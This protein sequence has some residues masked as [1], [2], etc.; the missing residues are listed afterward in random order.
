MCFAPQRHALFRHL[1]LNLQKWSEPLVFLTFWLR[2]VLRVTTAYTFSTSEP[3]KVVRTPGVFNILTSKCAW[4]HNGVHFFDIATSKS[5]P[6]MVCFVH[7]DLETCFA[8]QQRALFR[9]CNFQKWSDN[10]VFCIFWLGNVLRATT[11]CNFSSLIWPDGSA[12]AALAS[13]LFDP[14]EPQISGRLQWIATFLPFR[15]S[16]SSFFWLFLFSDLLSSVTLPIST[17]HLSILSE[18][19]LLNF[20]RKVLCVKELYE[21]NLCVKDCR[22]KFRSQTSDS[23]GRWKAETVEERKSEKRKSQKKEDAGARK[24][25]KVAKHSV[26]P[27]V[28]G[29]GGSKS[30]LAKAAGAEPS[31]QMRD[32]KLH[33]VVTRSAFRS[34][35]VPNTPS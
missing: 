35:H 32:E 28:S 25:R 34:Q 5:G 15:A 24:G 33:A 18:V 19:W 21:T 29:S 31:G 3:P 4:C 14:P 2:N 6:T 13:L 10:G 27:M 20:L 26:F 30:R 22:R 1:S 16:A 9:H 17:F 7:F 23:M 11:A 12:P 8:P